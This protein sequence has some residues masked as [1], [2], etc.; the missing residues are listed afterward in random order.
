MKQPSKHI[1]SHTQRKCEHTAGHMKQHIIAFI[2]FLRNQHLFFQRTGSVR[3]LV[4][5]QQITSCCWASLHWRLVLGAKPD[6][7]SPPFSPLTWKQ[8]QAINLLKLQCSWSLEFFWG[9][10]ARTRSISMVKH[11]IWVRHHGNT[12]SS[13]FQAAL[14]QLFIKDHTP[15]MYRT[16][17][18]TIDNTAY[19]SGQTLIL[20]TK[21]LLSWMTLLHLNGSP[22]LQ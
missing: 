19:N 18:L 14:T 5:I 8:S 7:L 3:G 11:W 16:F 10:S 4:E 9:Q 6:S 21:H 1:F 20:K 13:Q 22:V 17:R 12:K 15:K 2:S